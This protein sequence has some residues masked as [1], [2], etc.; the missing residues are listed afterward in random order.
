M[1]QIVFG[2]GTSHSPQL[3]TKP[4]QWDVHAERD[5]S[6]S[7]LLG[8]DGK[9]H[10]FDEL[11]EMT[12]HA[13]MAKEI[14]P[15]VY[16]RRYEANE[17]AMA[18]LHDKLMAANFDVA[19]ILGDDQQEL[20]LDDNMPAFGVYWGET[21]INQKRD[22]TNRPLGL[23]ISS[24]GYYHDTPTEYPGNASLGQHLAQSLIEQHFD[25]SAS[26]VQK[27]GIGMSHAVSFVHRR[28]MHDAKIPVVPVWVNTYYP[29]NQ[30]L[31]GRCIDFGKAVRN[32]IESW[33]ANKR[34]AV[35]ASGGLSHFVVDEEMDRAVLKALQEK[36]EA[37]LRAVPENK[38]QSGN[39]EA[40]NW[41][42]TGTALGDLPMH[43]V[44]YVPCYR[45][46]AGTGCAMAFAYWQ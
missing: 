38:L 10:S 1:A 13:A 29:P 31:I 40:K 30:P 19:V 24:W 35:I 42:A 7:Q 22:E 45:S 3:S 44:D 36:D 16:Q 43:L 15:D 23:R 8:A 20:L 4:E 28:I 26:R 37:A 18:K 12:N 11:L 6:K 17:R 46:L 41:A 34:V 27:Q 39:S 5:K 14:T 32:A 2:L 25:V 9:W 33:D 21:M